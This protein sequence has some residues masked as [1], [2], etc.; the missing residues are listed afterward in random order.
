MAKKIYRYENG[1][2]IEIL[3]YNP[4]R[5]GI[6]GAVMGGGV[7]LCEGTLFECL[8]WLAE[9]G[10]AAAGRQRRLYMASLHS[11]AMPRVERRNARR[12][13]LNRQRFGR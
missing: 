1:H 11:Q 10:D 4:S 3:G 7:C 9:R 8:S 13:F 2:T 12:P 6:I 5:R